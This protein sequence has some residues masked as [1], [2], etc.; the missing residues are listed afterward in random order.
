M[1]IL[2]TDTERIRKETGNAIF[3]GNAEDAAD[4]EW[5]GAR[6]EPYLSGPKFVAQCLE[7]AALLQE[8]TPGSSRLVH[9]RPKPAVSADVSG[10]VASGPGGRIIALFSPSG[11]AGTTTLAVTMVDLL[12]QQ[13]KRV[14]YLDLESI[15]AWRQFY[16]SESAYNLSDFLYNMLL[17]TLSQEEAVRCFKEMTTLQSRGMFFIEPC[18]GGEDLLVLEPEEQQELLSVLRQAFDVVVCDLDTGLTPFQLTVL[19]Q[20]DARIWIRAG[21]ES[22]QA[23]WEDLV[24][25]MRRKHRETLLQDERTYHVR[26]GAS[27]KDKKVPELWE[28]PLGKDLFREKDGLKWIQQNTE[29]YKKVEGL[30]REA[31]RGAGT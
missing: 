14:L 13:G 23:K 31:D 24:A 28:L 12:A 11:G 6:I 30:L 20:C 16:R 9:D 4:L 22:G 3:M 26:I 25:V 1:E 18:N 27:S 15:S 8:M 7:Q 10:N 21:V 19:E 2:L 17:D 29:W 5:R